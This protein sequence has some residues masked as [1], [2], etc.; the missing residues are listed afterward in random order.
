MMIHC[1]GP[2]ERL[3]RGG[4]SPCGL[5]GGLARWPKRKL[6]KGG[7]SARPIRGRHTFSGD[8]YSSI[9]PFN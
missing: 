8:L 9:L 3:R 4:A 7:N 5:E 2:T 6:K 1:Q